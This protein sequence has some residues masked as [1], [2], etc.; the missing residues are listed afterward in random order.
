M[1]NRSTTASLPRALPLLLTVATLACARSTPEPPAPPQPRPTVVTTPA[2]A[3]SPAPTPSA[4]PE[5]ARADTDQD[6]LADIDDECPEDPETYNGYQD[7]DGCPDQIPEPRTTCFGPPFPSIFFAD[8]GA[9]LGAEQRDELDKTIEVLQQYPDLRVE[10]RGH[11]DSRGSQ[12]A[13]L[14]FARQ[15]AE[16]VKRY[17]VRHGIAADRVE[18][19][20]IGGLEPI[21]TN[22]TREGRANNRRVEFWIV[23]R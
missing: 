11:T 18:T 14:E 13:N 21:A 23:R 7:E 5:L 6:K 8:G 15:R 16:A 22:D 19:R 4:Q 1:P 2:P 17:L 10:L 12:S 3:P 20:A 9:R